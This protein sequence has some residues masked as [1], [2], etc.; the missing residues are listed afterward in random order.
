M[1]HLAHLP[2]SCFLVL[3]LLLMIYDTITQRKELTDPYTEYTKHKINELEKKCSSKFNS[4]LAMMLHQTVAIKISD[5]SV[6]VI[7]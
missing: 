6:L 7:F 4:G 5:R 2:L 1:Y 3:L